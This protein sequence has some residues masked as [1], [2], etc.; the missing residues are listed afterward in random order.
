MPEFTERKTALETEKLEREISKIKRDTWLAPLVLMAQAFNTAC[1]VAIALVVLFYFQ[2]PQVEEQEKSLVATTNATV[3]TALLRVLEMAD[4]DQQRQ[5]R[6]LLL[7]LYPESTVLAEIVKSDE[8]IV[9]SQAIATKQLPGLTAARCNELRNQIQTL[10]AAEEDLS[11]RR[12]AEE[13]A[14]RYGSLVKALERQEEEVHLSMARQQFYYKS[15]EG[16]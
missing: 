14:S 15:L 4:K 3:S 8:A 9:A 2:R 6:K 1:L 16:C 13:L 7:K 5:A 11:S 12:R 10:E